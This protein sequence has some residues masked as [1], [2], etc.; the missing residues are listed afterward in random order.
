MGGCI[1]GRGRLVREG[2]MESE[3]RCEQSRSPQSEDAAR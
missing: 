1:S 2:G 3:F